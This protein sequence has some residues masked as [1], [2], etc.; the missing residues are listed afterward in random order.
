[1]ETQT[2][3]GTAVHLYNPWVPDYIRVLEKVRFDHYNLPAM[4]MFSGNLKI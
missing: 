2:R 4:D 3:I 1:V